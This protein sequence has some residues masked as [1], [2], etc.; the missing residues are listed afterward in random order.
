M[1]T[2]RTKKWTR[3]EEL[4]ARKLVEENL[5]N[6]ARVMR[7]ERRDKFASAALTGLLA[8]NADTEP[9]AFGDKRQTDAAFA[10]S[11]Y[12]LADAMLAE[13]ERRVAR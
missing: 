1:K 8:L 13:R 10:A 11:A 3:A 4:A 6:H 9:G 5:A 12:D 7:E 2:K